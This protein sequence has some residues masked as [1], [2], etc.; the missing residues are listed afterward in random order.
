MR[1]NE[2]EIKGPDYSEKTQSEARIADM[3]LL[4]AS[5]KAP[6]SSYKYPLLHVCSVGFICIVT[7]S[8]LFSIVLRF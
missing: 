8:I 2:A 6:C 7:L 4:E 3:G 5:P 1:W